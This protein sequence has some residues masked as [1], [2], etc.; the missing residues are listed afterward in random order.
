[1][2]LSDPDAGRGDPTGRV[3]GGKIVVAIGALLLLLIVSAYVVSKNYEVVAEGSLLSYTDA[4]VAKL[5]LFDEF[6][7]YV[8]KERPRPPDILNGVMLAM[9]AG[10]ALFA[11]ALIPTGDREARRIR[12]F[13]A[14]CW[15]GF[16]Y[17]AADELMGI[18]ET[19]GHNLQF[20]GAVPGVHRPDDVIFAAYVVPALLVLFIYRR[21]FLS[22]KL[23]LALFGT[24][25]GFFAVA[26]VMDIAGI[27]LD[28]LAEPLS[29]I[30]I[31]AGF[32]KL[33]L[34]QVRRHGHS[35][36]ADHPPQGNRAG[37]S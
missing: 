10:I 2:S 24:A 16:A 17:V 23:V 29:A 13:F 1:M 7:I 22:S 20:L 34:E 19:L 8:A 6:T 18:H 25:I 14:L 3:G 11:L 4:Q 32:M 27:G 9:L 26:G 33:A 30:F 36:S 5:R 31:L 37:L 12:V 28:E 35:D 15:T 21:M